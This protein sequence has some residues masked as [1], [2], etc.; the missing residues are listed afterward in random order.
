MIKKILQIIVQSF[1]KFGYKIK[2]HILNA[3]DFGLAQNRERLII[4]GSRDRYFNFSKLI[5]TKSKSIKDILEKEVSFEFLRSDEY[6]IL[7]KEKW[8]K[9]LSSLIFCGYRNKLIRINGVR[10]NTEHLS[11]IHKQSNRI[12]FVE[13]TH[14]TLLSQESSGRFWIYDGKKSKKIYS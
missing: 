6:T 2:W 12:Y 10:L 11:R 5:K 14:P 9:Q 1:E 4:I 7:P 13:G 8:K 3:K